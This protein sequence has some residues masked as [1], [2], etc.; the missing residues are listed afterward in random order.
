[1][2]FISTA[3]HFLHEMPAHIAIFA[4]TYGY[5]VY[6][7][8]FAIVFAETGLVVTPFLPGDSLLIAVGAVC[9]IADG[10]DL[11]T[12]LI[13]LC[14]AAVLGNTTNYL[15]GYWLSARLKAKPPRW[16]N[17]SYLK[18]TE[19]F[20]ENH[21]GKTLVLTRFL[22]I[23]RTYSPF[24]AGIARMPW[25]R[26]QFFNFTGG[27]LWVCSITLAGYFFGNLP[28]VKDNFLFIIIAVIVVSALPA[29]IEFIRSRR[30]RGEINS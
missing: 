9:A 3:L 7:L 8:L 6:V 13:L 23:L 30:L 11:S 20:Y 28:A 16:I 19:E 25:R 22:P 26:F 10:L 4:N 2:E 14:L 17:Q 1:M 29:V 27:I 21:G 18:R 15:I 24:V 12:T 5:L